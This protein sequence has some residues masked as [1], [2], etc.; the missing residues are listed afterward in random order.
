M[1]KIIYPTLLALCFAFTL[2]C[3]SGP[4]ALN[5]D[6]VVAQI[7]DTKITMGELNKAASDDL[8]KLDQEIYKIKRSVLDGM[9]EDKLIE[10]AA[11]GQGKS[12]SDYLKENIDGKVNEPTDE[13]LNKFYDSRKAQMGGKKFKDVKD[14][15]KNYLVQ[16]QTQGLRGQ[17]L[18]GLR[19]ANSVKINLE[20]PRVKID[21]GD[22][23]Y[24]G[25]KGAPITI[26]EFTDYQCPFCKRVRETI[27]KIMKDYEGKVKYVLAD[28]PLSFH[29][30]SQKAHEA[31]HCAGD[32]DKYWELNH[33][34]WNNQKDLK[35][36]SL[37]KYAA[38]IKL[39]TA[40]FNKCLDSGKYA[41][42]VKENAALGASSGASGTPAFFV[43]GIFLS[44]ARPYSDF[45]E[46]IDQELNK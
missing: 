27:D 38:D 41:D 45:K 39:D 26:V 25:P 28:F 3:N 13:D 40:K 2:S 31:A 24:K 1:K 8:G 34:L 19:S 23:P 9:V 12:V 14:M 11:S 6:D 16:G 33:V 18:A 42:K 46:I 5:S 21:I 17:L 35:V 10:L 30:Q 4:K 20:P 32:Q 44:G 22:N 36:E 15:I 43:N 7:G 37:K 29:Q